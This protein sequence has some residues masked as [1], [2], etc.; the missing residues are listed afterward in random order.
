MNLL[1]G[2]NDIQKEIK[3]VNNSLLKIKLSA[4]RKAKRMI[5][6][7]DCESWRIV[8]TADETDNDTARKRIINRITGAI[9]NAF[10]F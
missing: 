2:C 3:K 4:K 1:H 7:I 8:R 9:K 10:W 6:V 5:P